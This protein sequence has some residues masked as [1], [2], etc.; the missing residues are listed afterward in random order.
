MSDT[1]AVSDTSAQL[2]H[3]ADVLD[4]HPGLPATFAIH[5]FSGSP[6]VT[7]QVDTDAEGDAIRERLA[8]T[9]LYWITCTYDH[10]GRILSGWSEELQVTICT[11]QV[12]L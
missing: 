6:E 7:W 5:L 10:R 12:T 8:D 3:V 1:I 2:R 11:E 9:A 4:H